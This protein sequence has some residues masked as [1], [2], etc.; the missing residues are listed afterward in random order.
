MAIGLTLAKAQSEI[1]ALKAIE[2]GGHILRKQLNASV[3]D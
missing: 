1:A 2:I 3:I